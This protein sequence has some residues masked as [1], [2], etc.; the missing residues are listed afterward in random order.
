MQRTASEHSKPLDNARSDLPQDRDV[1]RHE[2]GFFFQ[3]MVTARTRFT[4]S[5]VTVP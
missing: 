1:S 5:S 4:A 3:V 2:D